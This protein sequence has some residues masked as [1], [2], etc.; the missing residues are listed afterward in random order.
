VAGRKPLIVVV[1]IDND[2]EQVLGRRV[3]I[4]YDDVRRAALEYGEKRPED[5]DLNAMFAGLQLYK[6]F[7]EEG[8]DPEIIVVGGHEV[9]SLE[10]QR[11]IKE[12]VRDLVSKIGAPVEF[13]IVSDGEDEMAVA[14][15]LHDF[16]EIGGFRRVVVE[17]HLGIEGNYLLIFKY[18]RKAV[19]DPKY[20]RYFVGVPG[21][22][23]FLLSIMAI[24]DV[25]YLALQVLAMLIGIIMVIRGFNLEEPL[26]QWTRRMIEGIRESPHFNIAGILMLVVFAAAG[27][28]A[29][30]SVYKEAQQFNTLVIGDIMR[31]TIPLIGA[32]IVSYVLITK[33]FYKASIGDLNILKDIEV[34]VVV[35]AVSI[36]FFNLGTY[37][38]THFAGETPSAIPPTAFT[39]SG[40]IQYVII[41][42][43][44]AA[45]IEL[46]RRRLYHPAFE[47]GQPGG[48]QQATSQNS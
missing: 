39:E 14:E 2:V 32:G 1:D 30:Y 45:L 5:A 38:K 29:G 6:R 40:F 22:A 21:I 24:L 10:A 11:R 3:I 41:G 23:L 42:T 31:T 15:V 18:L 36:G 7:R 26:E 17:Q 35:A 48:S 12:S 25:A 4:G 37:L 46:L 44:I 33:L 8:L 27:I 47:E 13:Y 16:G 9:D 43:G 28:Y 20:A 34:M 19:Q